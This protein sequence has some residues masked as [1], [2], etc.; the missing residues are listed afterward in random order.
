MKAVMWL[1]RILSWL[2]LPIILLS[3]FHGA[4]GHGLSSEERILT[5]IAVFFFF[6]FGFIAKVAKKRIPAG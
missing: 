5:L 2:C 6:T 3:L 4:G 1:F